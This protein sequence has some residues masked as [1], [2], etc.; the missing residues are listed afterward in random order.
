MRFLAAKGALLSG[1]ECKKGVVLAN[2]AL[3]LC[4]PEAYSESGCTPGSAR[5]NASS[6]SA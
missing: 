2:D 1:F 5:A 6:V 3:F 4:T